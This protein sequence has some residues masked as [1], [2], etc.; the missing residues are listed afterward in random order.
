MSRKGIV[1]G[2]WKCNPK[3]VS[4]AQA[5][6]K[7]V[8]GGAWEASKVDVVLFPVALHA[9]PA[10]AESKKA[11]IGMQNPYK[12]G[13]FTGEIS[14]DQIKDAGMEWVLVGHSE[15][16]HVFKESDAL[17]AERVKLAQDNGLQVIYCIGELLEER[18]SGKTNDVCAQQLDAVLASIT[19]WSR[20]V[21]AYEPVWAIGTGKVASPEQAQEAHK[22]VRELIATKVSADVAAA[23]RIQYGGSVNAGNC[24]ELIALPDVD[25]FLV[26]GAA[27]KPEF[28]DIIA[29]VQG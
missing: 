4:E 9:L 13:A 20:V 19:D 5:L 11:K 10:Q 27:L 3:T 16:R 18:E 28:L 7:A 29:A 6:A 8:E 15:R 21:L 14:V 25:G 1:G 2:N 22:A 12:A 23:I 24:K 26:G 17:L